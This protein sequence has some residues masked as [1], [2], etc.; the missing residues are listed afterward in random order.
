MLFRSP[1]L[2]VSVSDPHVAREVMRFVEAL[3][4]LDDVQDVYTNMD[5][6]E[7]ILKDLE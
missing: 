5:V 4:D 6:D 3:E 1:D 2:W 7:S